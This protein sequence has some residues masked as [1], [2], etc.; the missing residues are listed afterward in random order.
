MQVVGVE[1]GEKEITP[2]YHE[3]YSQNSPDFISENKEILKAV[4]KVS[5][6]VKE[7]GIW[8]IDR[9]GDR[10]RVFKHLLENN[11]RFIVRLVGN[12]NLVYL[13]QRGYGFELSRKLSLII[14]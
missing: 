8:T 14:Q 10:G 4:E 12:R 11:K 7:R 3:L 13:R 1:C 5:K 2:L 9:G 6:H